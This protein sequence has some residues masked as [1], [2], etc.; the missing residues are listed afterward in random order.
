MNDDIIQG[1]VQWKR[2]ETY[3]TNHK[4]DGMQKP[5]PND[6]GLKPVKVDE[7][8]TINIEKVCTEKQLMEDPTDTLE[9]VSALEKPPT[10]MKHTSDSES[11]D[12][13]DS[14]LNHVGRILEKTE[15]TKPNSHGL[16]L[17]YV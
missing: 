15:K 12:P 3:K 16:D 9:K 10:E 2:V 17:N 13:N 7:S 1:D 5:N 14:K 8:N 11:E 6:E 4:C